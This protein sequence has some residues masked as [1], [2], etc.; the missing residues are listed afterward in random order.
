MPHYEDSEFFSQVND[1]KTVDV[2]V[3][4][5]KLTYW[6][7]NKQLNAGDKYNQYFLRK[8]Y[9]CPL[10]FRDGKTRPVDLAVCGSILLNEHVSGCRRV[11]GCGIQTRNN[12]ANLPKASAYLA[13]RGRITQEFVQ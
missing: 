4:E 12:Y 11:V 5:G 7:W 2:P 9:S 13:V 3:G 8:V 10:E 1:F 6:Y